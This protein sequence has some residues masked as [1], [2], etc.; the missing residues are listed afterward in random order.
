MSTQ[1]TQPVAAVAEVAGSTTTPSGLAS[2]LQDE[3]I[4]AVKPSLSSASSAIVAPSALEPVLHPAAP[5]VALAQKE[6]QEQA[7]VPMEIV[8]EVVQPAAVPAPG[9]P[10]AVVAQAVEVPASAAQVVPVVAPENVNALPFQVPLPAALLQQAPDEPKVD[11]ANVNPGMHVYMRPELYQDQ[12]KRKLSAEER[13]VRNEFLRKKNLEIKKALWKKKIKQTTGG[14]WQDQLSTNKRGKV[15]FTKKSNQMK[16]DPRGQRIA[17]WGM[18]VKAAYKALGLTGFIP[19][20]GKTEKGQQLLK[21]AHEFYD[22]A[23][24]MQEGNLKKLQE[25]KN[26][27]AKA[28][29]E[30]KAAAK[31]VKDATAINAAAINQ[32]AVAA[33]VNGLA[34][35]SAGQAVLAALLSGNVNNLNMGQSQMISNTGLNQNLQQQAAAAPGA[36][37]VGNN[38][39]SS[40]INVSAAGLGAPAASGLSSSAAASSSKAGA[41][42]GGGGGS[43]IVAGQ[44]PAVAVVGAV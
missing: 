16:S 13:K 33:L 2:T 29:A 25:Q 39:A 7:P 3:T 40:V 26:Q 21:K 24:K 35:G 14:V 36:A 30:R 12:V 15:V 11:L 42:S 23:K 34:G 19:C 10:A 44:G 4:V 41:A 28:M 27:A 20:G 17:M 37:A 38:S 6:Q 5:V 43:G 18:S 8:Q 1:L 22:R 31:A 32:Q 9:G